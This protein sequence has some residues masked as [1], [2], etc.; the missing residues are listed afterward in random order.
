MTDDNPQN[1]KLLESVFSHE[2]YRILKAG[3]GN[4]AL[5]IVRTGEVDL[6]LMDVTKPDLAEFKIAKEIKKLRDIPIIFIT[7]LTDKQFVIEGLRCGGDEFV[8]VPFEPGQLLLHVQNLLKLKEYQNSMK[9]VAEQRARKLKHMFQ[10][11]T[12]ANR[13]V[14]H[15]LLMVSEYRD[16]E[17]GRHIV[18]VGK[19]SRLIAAGMG[20]GK[21]FTDF[22]EET[23]PAHDLGKIG[24]PDDIL[25]KP[26][27]LTEHEFAIM[28]THSLIGANILKKGTSHM[29]KMACEIALS[30]H[31]K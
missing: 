14:I 22:I 20:H 8:S 21:R 7:G 12:D 27:K 1:L 13:E 4:E 11:W 17:T 30:H 6:I 29:T 15:R 28:K 26:G 18:R 23:A 25:L 5:A 24:I 9:R 16:D 2:D 31:E 10:K 3:N 19:Y